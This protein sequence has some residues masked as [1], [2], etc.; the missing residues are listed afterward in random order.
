MLC[1]F[2]HKTSPM[3]FFVHQSVCV[4][5]ECVFVYVYPSV[6]V[7][8]KGYSAKKNRFQMCYHRYYLES[9]QHFFSMSGPPKHFCEDKL[10]FSFKTYIYYF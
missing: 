2:V 6:W 1:I 4:C 3:H 9:F 8:W 7:F 10:T 5:G